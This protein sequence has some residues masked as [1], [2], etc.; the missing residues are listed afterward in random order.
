MTPNIVEVLSAFLPA[1]Q[2]KN[3]TLD[4]VELHG[5]G[6]LSLNITFDFKPDCTR[7]YEKFS[8][9]PFIVDAEGNRKLGHW[10]NWPFDHMYMEVTPEQLKRI[11]EE[12]NAYQI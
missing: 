2:F 4:D 12:V 7:D 10:F 1:N 5:A 11:W 8:C 3:V 6:G 9:A